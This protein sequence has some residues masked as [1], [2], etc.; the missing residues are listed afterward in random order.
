MKTE[1][2]TLYFT[3][4][5]NQYPEFKDSEGNYYVFGSIAPQ[6]ILNNMLN[7]IEMMCVSANELGINFIEVK[8]IPPKKH[9]KNNANNKRIIEIIN[10]LTNKP[11]MNTGI[12]CEVL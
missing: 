7:L 12:F 6:Y 1:I 9:W 4:R 11:Y 3:I 2:M 10:P 5:K 8:Y